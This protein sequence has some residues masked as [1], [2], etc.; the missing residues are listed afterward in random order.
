[1]KILSSGPFIIIFYITLKCIIMEERKRL[2]TFT[3]WLCKIVA[4]WWQHLTD[5]HVLKKAHMNLLLK[6]GKKKDKTVLVSFQVW[7]F[8]F[9]DEMSKVPGWQPYTT[10]PLWES[11]VQL[12]A[13]VLRFSDGLN[14][15][16]RGL[17]LTD[18]VDG[19]SIH[20]IDLQGPQVGF[21]W[22]IY[23]PCLFW[24]TTKIIETKKEGETSDG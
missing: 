23:K 10:S 7:W 11:R 22:L 9:A 12:S 6:W 21:L 24:E 13:L 14:Q 15:A 4:D 17:F 2:V 1:M 5:C 16:A 19:E 3:N 18:S 20:R 8:M